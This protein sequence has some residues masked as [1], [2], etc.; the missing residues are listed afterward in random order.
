MLTLV[1]APG[2]AGKI[3]SIS[4][5]KGRHVGISSPGSPT[6]QFLNF[7]LISHGVPPEDVSVVSIGTTASSIAA[8][9]HGRVDAAALVGSSVTTFEQRHPAATFLADTRSL[10]GAKRVFGFINFPNAS[11][12]TTDDWLSK[13]QDT[14]NG[15]HER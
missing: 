12:V 13:N 5:L 8:L 4:D 1:I 14:L 7:L 3:Y 15:L 6:H 10:A 2:M 11:V 9:E